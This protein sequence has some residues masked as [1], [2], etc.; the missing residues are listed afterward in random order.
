MMREREKLMMRPT[1]D[2]WWH[3]RHAHQRHRTTRYII[4]IT[5]LDEQGRQQARFDL[6]RV[7]ADTLGT[8]ISHY[9]WAAAQSF[10]HLH[11]EIVDKG[12]TIHE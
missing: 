6:E 3:N 10:L 2:Q 8:A 1:F 11:I 9:A 7:G 12:E 4:R 5:L